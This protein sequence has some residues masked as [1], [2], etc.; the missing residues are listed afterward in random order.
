MTP[1]ALI[2]QVST[3][4]DTVEFDQIMD[5]IAEHYTY[6]PSRFEN[7]LGQQ[8]VVNE[9]GSNEG[10]CKIFGFGR[11]AGLDEARTLACFGRYYREDVLHN[12]EGNEHA[13]IRTFMRDGWAGI[14]FD[15]EPLG[16]KV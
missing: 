2:E 15:R 11:I 7:G 12:P 1:E 3:A 14:R 13:N 9:A 4:A 5:V 16:R 6:T 8:P 10:S